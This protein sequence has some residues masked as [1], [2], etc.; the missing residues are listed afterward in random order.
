MGKLEPRT[1]ET[2]CLNGRSW[3]P[4][5]GD[6]RIV[7]MHESHKSKYFIHP[8]SYKMYQDIKRLYW[9]PKMKA[10]IATY[11]S[12]CLTCAKVKSEHQRPIG[13]V[14]TTRDTLYG[15]W[16][17]R[18]MMDFVHEASYVSPGS[19]IKLARMYLKSSHEAGIPFSISVIVDHS[20]RI[21]FWRS[22][23]KGFG[24]YKFGYEYCLSIRKTD[25]DKA[26]ETI[27]TSRGY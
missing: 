22:L 8:G 13:F 23:Q 15:K 27:Q 19:G 26:D 6:L 14:S 5:Y 3:L 4:C 12:K 17:Q 16:G 9:W 2:M 20:V 11:V 24:F 21:N 25:Q 10:N 1:D 7:I 18:S